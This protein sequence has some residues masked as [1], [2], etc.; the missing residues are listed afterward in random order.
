LEITTDGYFMDINTAREILH[1][2]QEFNL[3]DLE[4]A[5]KRVIAAIHPDKYPAE[6]KDIFDRLTREAVDAYTC[7]LAS[8]SSSNPSAKESN[9]EFQDIVFDVDLT[10]NNTA[11]NYVKALTTEWASK[12]PHHSFNSLGNDIKIRKLSYI[13]GYFAL[14][15]TT[16]LTRTLKHGQKP[17]SGERIPSKTIFSE[18]DVNIWS[19]AAHSFNDPFNTHL[20]KEAP[21]TIVVN[22]SQEVNQC[23]ECGGKGK[24]SCEKC[25]SKG[26]G[27]CYEC[28]GLKRIKC[29]NCK[30]LR[31]KRCNDCMGSGRLSRNG[32]D[33]KCASCYGR[34]Y[35]TCSCGDG[36]I[37][38]PVCRGKGI[39]HCK[40][41]NGSGN[42]TCEECAGKGK[43]ISAYYWVR[44]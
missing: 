41:C 14:L 19:F 38:C 26:Y 24:I 21:K 16:I 39:L 44:L 25:D 3:K 15:S 6:R 18:S 43:M 1:L 36:H 28:G 12:I 42:V 33:I 31:E 17:Y 9:N 37:T 30:G 11:V 2:G 27:D 4:R 8:L 7:L 34:G 35:R 20:L 22:G 13:P 29:P 10:A 5:K 32:H 40:I 23:N